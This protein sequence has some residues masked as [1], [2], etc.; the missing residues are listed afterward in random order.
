MRANR[1][2]YGGDRSTR[3][4]VVSASE[5]S[6]V[7]L[8]AGA[9]APHAARCGSDSSTRNCARLRSRIPSIPSGTS[10]TSDSTSRSEALRRRNV[11]GS[12]ASS[13]GPAS[14]SQPRVVQVSR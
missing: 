3:S 11:R 12:P 5:R 10:N 13:N 8:S 6:V 7:T 1:L 9:S 2:A 4:V 14:N